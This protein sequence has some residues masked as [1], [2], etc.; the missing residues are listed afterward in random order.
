MATI[1]V[2]VPVY[3]VETYLRK[4]I[5]SI[6]SQSMADIEILLVD[7]GSTD[8]S[9]RICDEYAQKDNRIRVIH[10]DNGGLSD[11]RNAGIEA[12]KGA[13]IGFV[14]SDDY[15]APDMYETLYR[16]LL[17]E[18]ADLSICN[19]TYVDENDA[20]IPERNTFR[21]VKDEILSMEGA[22][23]KLGSKSGYIFVAACFKL[24]R[25]QLFESL[26][27]QKGKIIE[28]EYIVH[29]VFGSC[30]K[31]VCVSKP[32]YYYRQRAHSIMNADYNV[33]RLDGVEAYA[34][35]LDFLQQR[36]LYAYMESAEWLYSYLLLYG[37][38][39]LDLKDPKNKDRVY[40]L[41]KDFHKRLPSLLKNKKAGLREKFWYLLFDFS[42]S[43]YQ[44]IQRMYTGMT[45][46][47]GE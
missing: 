18:D 41:R 39:H 11:A 16:A 37:C 42:P 23:G 20:E 28:D 10:K 12:A 6:L 31:I 46:R 25:R 1:S 36:H 7:D 9:G 34:D 43:F 15:I 32:L 17:Q 33:A 19:V 8:S 3:N 27:F 24:Y 44:K 47:G 22:F 5:D 45:G 13:W 14:D 35:R 21:P 38:R 2:I 30:K 40:E 26:R 4:C 29:H